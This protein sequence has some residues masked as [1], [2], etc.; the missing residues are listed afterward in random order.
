MA[1]KEPD[2]DRYRGAS[3]FID[4]ASS[5][6]HTE[7]QVTLNAA[8]T[9]VAKDNFERELRRLGVQ[10]QSYHTD[11]G[12]YVSNAF[13]EELTKN[14]QIPRLSGVGAKWQNLFSVAKSDC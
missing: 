9:I 13:T 5:Y 7:L 12:I 11:N 14:D 10:V 2:K 1:G 6:I 3:I 8:D 4:A